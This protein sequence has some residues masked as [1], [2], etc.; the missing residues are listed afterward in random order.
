M[1]LAS[2]ESAPEHAKG[3]DNTV[4]ETS[5][6]QPPSG[7]LHAADSRLR[8]LQQL[9]TEWVVPQLIAAFISERNRP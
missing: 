5:V 7:G 1:N 6:E 2:T 8:E 4:A 9:I 3:H